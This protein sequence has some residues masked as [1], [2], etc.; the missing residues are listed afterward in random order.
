MAAET[1]AEVAQ[2]AQIEIALPMAISEKW[3]I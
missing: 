1:L 2:G 3:Q